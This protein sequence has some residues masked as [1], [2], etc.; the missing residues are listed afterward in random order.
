MQARFYLPM[1]GRFASPDPA[2]DQHFEETQSW[3]IYS[4]VQ[5]NPMMMTD[6]TGMYSFK[7]LVQDTKKVVRSVL[8]WR[9]RNI[10]QSVGLGRVTNK[11]A[12]GRFA[13]IAKSDPKKAAEITKNVQV[14]EM[15]SQLP[16]AT[17]GGIAPLSVGPTAFRYVSEGEAIFADKNGFIPNT[18]LSGE[19]KNVFLSPQKFS[20]AAEA[21]QALQIGK[22][23]PTGATASP[24]HV[25]TGDISKTSFTYAGSVEGSTKGI[26]MVTQQKVPVVKIE[27]LGK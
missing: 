1:Y 10:N 12:P 14:Q 2:R 5:N 11:E 26:E 18:T 27:P 24:T 4:Y 20:S 15:V 9:E 17:C 25:I 7:E 8:N 13:Q 21:E 19:A 22:S 3:N 23:N 16:L 6:P